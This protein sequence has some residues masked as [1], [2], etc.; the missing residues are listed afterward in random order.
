[1][2]KQL[3][4]YNISFSE[5]STD[6]CLVGCRKKG[7]PTFPFLEVMLLPNSERA[8][9]V[10]SRPK[11]L[12]ISQYQDSNAP[13]FC[14]VDLPKSILL[15]RGKIYARWNWPTWLDECRSGSCLWLPVKE[16]VDWMLD[17]AGYRIGLKNGLGQVYLFR[18]H[19]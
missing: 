7:I 15:T 18:K 3:K 13:V 16:A 11:N 2:S 19:R 14:F 6:K 17:H 12:D 5:W 4:L 9:I 10:M 8:P 1:M